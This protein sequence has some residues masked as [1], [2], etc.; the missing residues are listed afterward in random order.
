MDSKDA[1]P[2]DGSAKDRGQVSTTRI[3]NALAEGDTKR[4]AE[5][6]G[7][8]HR[9]YI[10]VNDST[11]LTAN[12]ISLP[13]SKVLN[14]PPAAGSYE[15]GLYFEGSDDSDLPV[16]QVRISESEIT[17]ESQDSSLVNKI[18]LQSRIALDF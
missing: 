14:Q 18:T 3:R 16:V 9:L 10:E 4:V 7:R 5:L 1:P 8:R 6:L 12:T 11:V 13:I 2:V 17:L 15:C